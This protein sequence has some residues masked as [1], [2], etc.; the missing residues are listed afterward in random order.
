MHMIMF[1]PGGSLLSWYQSLVPC[2]LTTF[3][4][5]I[6]LVWYLL[7]GASVDW[8]LVLAAIQRQFTIRTWV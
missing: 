6:S 4:R 3:C 1:V 8:E 5:N 2:V 7:T